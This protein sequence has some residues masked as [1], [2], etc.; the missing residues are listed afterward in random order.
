[1][2]DQSAE[3][4]KKS[5]VAKMGEP[6][7]EVYSALWQDVAVIFVYWM[8]YVELFGT[9]SERIDLLN[10]VA[11]AFFRMLQD[12]LWNMSLLHIARLTDAANSQGRPDRPNLT[13]Q[14]LPALIAD[15]K[16]KDEVSELV[17]SA[18][19]ETEFCRDWRNRYIAHRDLKLA[20]EQ[21]TT[22]LKDASRAQVNS[23]LNAIAAVL[24]ALA[25]HYLQSETRFDLTARHNSAVALL[26][27]MD[28]GLMAK[29]ERAKR[30]L[31]GKHLPGD[32]AAKDI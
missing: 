11:P 2:A 25:S 27:L 31:E 17:A 18:L 19:K 32:L 24:N 8:D 9:K 16:F 23:A 12:E 6:L 30:L 29:E 20:L 4:A 7:G 14:A 26:Y 15:A 28:E 22:P 5:N 13:I 3:D 10:R 21:P 1:M